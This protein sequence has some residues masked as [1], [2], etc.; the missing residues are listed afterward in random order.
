MKQLIYILL[1]SIYTFASKPN[2][3]LL[4]TYKDQNIT[5]WVMS[6]KLD[7]I[8]AYWNG[9]NLISRNMENLDFLFIYGLGNLKTN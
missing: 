9:E 2:L 7:G 1:L 5:G 3:L 4:K 6:E 8:R